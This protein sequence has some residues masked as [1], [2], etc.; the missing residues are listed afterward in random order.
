M[1]EDFDYRNHPDT[2]KITL[3]GEELPFFIG[4]KSFALAKEEGI[5]Y[6][7]VLKAAQD[8]DESDI[9]G[10]LDNFGKLVWIGLLV[11]DDIDVSWEQVAN[12]LTTKQMQRIGDKMSKAFG[13]VI[14]EE[15][16]AGKA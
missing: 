6:G 16:A 2:I 4:R 15:A 9:M 8:P 1:F 3:A 13:D 11:F 7:D 14:E 12:L 10:N 5:E